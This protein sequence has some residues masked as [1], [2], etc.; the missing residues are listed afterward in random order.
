M[1]PG[2]DIA[3]AELLVMCGN[4]LRYFVLGP[5]LDTS[6]APIWPDPGKWGNNVIGGPRPFECS[7]RVRDRGKLEGIERLYRDAFGFWN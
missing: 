3:D 4:L 1:C 5:R 2:Q 6:G 7:I